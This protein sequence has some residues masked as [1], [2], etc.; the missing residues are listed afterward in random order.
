MIPS[1]IKICRP[2]RIHQTE[3]ILLIV[4]KWCQIIYHTTFW[5]TSIQF[6]KV[7]ACDLTAPSHYL[8]QCW[9]SKNAIFCYLP[10]GNATGNAEDINY[11]K[12]FEKDSFEIALT[13]PIKGN[14]YAI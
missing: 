7:M 3:N 10:E 5:S 12:V 4:A 6:V 14:C 1:L 11:R 13:P 9:L 8:C 2:Y